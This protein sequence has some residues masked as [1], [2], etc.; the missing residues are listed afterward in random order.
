MSIIHLWRR[1]VDIE[2]IFAKEEYFVMKSQWE[3][4]AKSSYYNS[5]KV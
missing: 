2:K 4:T 5:L 1:I 3:A